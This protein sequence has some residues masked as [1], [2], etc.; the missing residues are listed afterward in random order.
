MRSNEEQFDRSDEIGKS[1]G[2][3]F[4]VL[5]P[6]GPD[7]HLSGRH[8]QELSP[9][10]Q[11]RLLSCQKR[12]LRL[13]RLEVFNY[14]PTRAKA[15]DYIGNKH[16][17]NVVAGFSPRSPSPPIPPSAHTAHPPLSPPLP[18]PLTRPSTAGHHS[19]SPDLPAPHASP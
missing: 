15:R 18:L 8:R 3:H 12:I 7:R 9:R 13:E 19:R 10:N 11:D 1:G 2:R 16:S 6:H 5:R 17:P 4:Q 14:W